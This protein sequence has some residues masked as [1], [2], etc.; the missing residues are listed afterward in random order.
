MVAQIEQPGLLAELGVRSLAVCGMLRC[1]GGVVLGL[2]HRAANYQP[3]MWQLAPAGS[4][5]S[6]AVG[7][8]GTIDLRRQLLRELRE[9]LGVVPDVVDE[10]QP[11]CIVEYAESHICDLGLGLVT[12]LSA[13][14]GL[15]APAAAATR[16]TSELQ[17]CRRW[18]WRGSWPGRA[19]CWC[20]RHASSWSGDSSTQ[21]TRCSGHGDR[22]GGELTG[23]VYVATV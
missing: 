13:E 10:P 14:A 3:G 7:A 8:D 12:S 5:D 23:G 22:S 19:E 18:D 16:S 1:P 11:L 17:W 9:E 20:Q 21:P 6:G 4:V 15:A 2:R